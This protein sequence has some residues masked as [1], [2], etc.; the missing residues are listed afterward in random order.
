MKLWIEN[1]DINFKPDILNDYINELNI[2]WLHK[3]IEYNM[4]TQ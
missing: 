2:T 4:V 1:P 3:W